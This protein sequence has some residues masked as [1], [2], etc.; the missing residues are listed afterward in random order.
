LGGED[1]RLQG[2]LDLAGIPYAGSGAHA[3]SLALHKP[4]CQA[5]LRA[6]G[7]PIAK[8]LAIGSEGAPV[9]DVIAAIGLPCVVKPARGGSSVGVTVVRD[10]EALAGAIALA[11]SVD[12]GALVEA[13]V[14]GREL[15]GGVLEIN[16]RPVALPLT[17][18]VPPE[19]RF[20][21]Y[22][23]KYET[24]ASR[25]LTPAPL[26]DDLT[27]EL[28]RLARHAHLAL[29]CRGF[30]RVDFILGRDGRAVVL[31]V[32]TIPG[33]TATSLLPQAA[34][35]HGIPFDRLIETMLDGAR[36]D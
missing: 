5:V 25:E 36:R 16:G 2:A 9:G 18:I 14:E 33:M 10:R 19:G 29:G 11:F 26:E 32:N 24:G 3:S 7:L 8:S 30:S 20:F 35:A 4:H 17:E 31:E 34:A 27:R 22:E 23:A 21:D 6:A 13:F 28:R 1:G 15:T 12:E